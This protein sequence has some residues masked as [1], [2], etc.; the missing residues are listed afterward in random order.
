MG[1]IFTW[2]LHRNHRIFN[3][4]RFFNSW[5]LLELE[6][7]C[8]E[9]NLEDLPE[10]L[11]MA[12]MKV[13]TEKRRLELL[14]IARSWKSPTACSHSTVRF[15]KTC[16]SLHISR[17]RPS[18]DITL[19]PTLKLQWCPGIML[20]ASNQLTDKLKI[21]Q[22]ALLLFCSR[23]YHVTKNLWQWMFPRDFGFISLF[24]IFFQGPY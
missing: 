13:N 5:L 15:Q 4:Y 1:W 2:T 12:V 6:K 14:Q 22:G 18:N 9:W 23:W 11:A 17:G 10:G 7:G 19:E 21:V 24:Y 16:L 20:L 3:I 8:L